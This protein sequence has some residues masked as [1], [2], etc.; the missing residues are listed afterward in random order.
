MFNKLFPILASREND[1]SHSGA[2]Q[3]LPSVGDQEDQKLH[4]RW[5]QVAL[6]CFGGISLEGAPT[7]GCIPEGSQGIGGHFL[8]CPLAFGNTLVVI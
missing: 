7:S 8:Q 4:W 5:L 6:Q 2:D 3:V 1:P